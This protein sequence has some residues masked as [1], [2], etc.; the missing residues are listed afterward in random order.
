MSV[1]LLGAGGFLGLNTFDALR[2]V[3]LDPLC[4]R[5]RRS[6]VLGLRQ[7]GARLVEADLDKPD[8][9]REAMNGCRTVVHLAGHYP[10][11][12]N[13]PEESVALGVHQTRTV[14]DAAAAA[15][16]QRL[17]YVSS[18]ATVARRPDASSTEA[19]TFDS[20]PGFGTYHRLKWAM[21]AL[22]GS[23][24]RFLTAT[25]CPGACLG[26]FDWKVGTSALLWQILR[27][28]PLA[29]PDGIISW[30]DARD[31]GEALARLA[32]MSSP[33]P[34]VLLSA[35]SVSA[36]ALLRRVVER[37]GS[38]PLPEPLSPPEAQAL[39]DAEEE[40][41][42]GRGTRPKLSREIVDLVV[43]GAPIDAGLSK[44]ALGQTYRSF[45]ETLLAFEGWAQAMGAHIPPNPKVHP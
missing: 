19:D 41:A 26:A 14:L 21:E 24:R 7:R 30:V 11:F 17:V 36:R 40:A 31:V 29:Y 8:T 1:L 20:A 28:E 3:G 38:P 37:W 43:H 44:A 10:R 27:K 12:S 9:L 4:G 33:P 35:G 22:V 18:T 45:D 39:A 25:V 5:R 6:N 42:A 34:R 16:V 2:A 32:T 15:G 13:T 23:E